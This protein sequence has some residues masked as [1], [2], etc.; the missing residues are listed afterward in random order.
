[1]NR[2]F[3]VLLISMISVSVSAQNFTTSNISFGD[4]NSGLS[5]S[6]IAGGTAITQSSD[7]STITSLN[8]VAC[9]ADNDSYYRR[10]DLDNDHGIVTNFDVTSLEFATETAA[11]IGGTQDLIVNL[12]SISNASPLLLANLT[13][14]GTGTVNVAD[15]VASVQNASV[16]GSVNGATDD[17][18]VEIVA[19]DTLNGTTYFIGS[20]ANGQ[21][22]P[23]FIFSVGCGADEIT[24]I[25]DLGFPGMHIIMIVNGTVFIPPP[26]I[27]PSLSTIGLLLLIASML[28]LSRRKR[29]FN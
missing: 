24:D 20:N 15:G 7:T 11:G 26:A 16:T 5:V 21:S 23:S 25:A 18:V 17:L 9:P 2:F 19:N 27:I 10:F 12:Y 6:G 4:V 28:F 29:L 8:S 3:S 14:I 22:A 1:M 13:L